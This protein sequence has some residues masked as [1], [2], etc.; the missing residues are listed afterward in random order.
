MCN[1][2]QISA[3]ISLGTHLDF[4]DCELGNYD[5][6]ASQLLKTAQCLF[7]GIEHWVKFLKI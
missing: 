1:P 6:E 4:T 2:C 5:V 7:S 3:K